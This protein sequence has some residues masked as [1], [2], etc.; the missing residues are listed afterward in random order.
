M[1]FVEFSREMKDFPAFSLRD[2]AKLSSKVYHHRLIEWQK[3]GYITRV[4]NGIYLFSDAEVNEMYLYYLS[5]RVYEPSYISLESAFSFYGF[6]PESVYRVTAV[7]TRKT[8][9]TSF[10]DIIF[11]YR[12]VGRS[13]FF[14]YTLLNWK[15]TVIKMAEPEKA[16]IDYLYL[17]PGLNSPEKISGM[18]FNA[19]EIMEKTDWNKMKEYLQLF[20]NKALEKRIDI[21]E[22]VLREYD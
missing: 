20:R 10:T 22:K 12:T 8:W 14:G 3:K 6:I 7:S 1:N 11:S 21:L 13:C 19:G 4:A 5:G 17:N 15:N 2:A 18:R 9:K 16:I